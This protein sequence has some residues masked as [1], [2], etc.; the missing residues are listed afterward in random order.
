M[1][2]VVQDDADSFA[3]LGP[4]GQLFDDLTRDQLA[5]LR[6]ALD[7]RLGL[8]TSPAHLAGRRFVIAIIEKLATD[9]AAMAQLLALDE[10]ERAPAAD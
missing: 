10:P 7:E 8:T 1:F 5:A 6:D 3:V 4:R 2:T 9:P